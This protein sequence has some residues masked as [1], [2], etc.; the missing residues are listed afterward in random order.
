MKAAV[1]MNMS[2]GSEEGEFSADNIKNALDESGIEYKIFDI[3]ST[4]PLKPKDIQN[5]YDTLIAAG[6]DGT[7]NFAANLVYSTDIALAV[8]P[9]GTLNHFAKDIGMPL[10]LEDTIG[11]IKSNNTAKLDAASVNDEIF[12]NNSSIGLYALAVR[13][14]DIEQSKKGWGKWRAMFA[15]FITVFKRFPLYTIN[16]KIDGRTETFRSPIIFIGNNEYNLDLFSL[17]TRQILNKGVLSIYI[18]RC[19]TRFGILKLIFSVLINRLMLNKDF[20][21]MLATEIEINSRKHSL[22]VAY[23]GEVKKVRTPIIYK[24]LPGKLKVILPKQ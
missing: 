1:I 6:G 13:H 9:A 10:T 19:K 5:K 7:V 8:I 20:D 23:D 3:G 11:V 18:A 15:A 12:I 17:G 21:E 24:I 2:A 22:D 4:Q 14:R 16:I